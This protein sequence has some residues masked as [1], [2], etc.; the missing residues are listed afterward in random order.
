MKATKDRARTADAD[1]APSE[2]SV[3]GAKGLGRL[4]ELTRKV[5]RVPVAEVRKL[6]RKQQRRRK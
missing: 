6:E 3:D 5:V 4:A 2:E 1:H